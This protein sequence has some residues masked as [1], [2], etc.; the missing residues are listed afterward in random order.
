VAWNLFNPPFF[1]PFHPIHETEGESGFGKAILFQ[2]EG[3]KEGLVG[4]LSIL[5]FR[6]AGPLAGVSFAERFFCPF[7]DGVC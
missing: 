1:F 2:L 4:Y 5:W 3:V 6:G 7:Y